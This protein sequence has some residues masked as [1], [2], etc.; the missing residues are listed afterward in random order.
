MVTTSLKS[1][2]YDSII[3]GTAAESQ[4]GSAGS[5]GGKRNKKELAKSGNT[6]CGLGAIVLDWKRNQPGKEEQRMEL[7]D[8]YDE[9]RN[10]TGRVH[11]RGTPWLPGEFGVV[12]CVWV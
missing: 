3:I 4:G 7:N 2:L 12:V 10:L 1:D 8:I 5:G 9:Y 11:Q 6:G